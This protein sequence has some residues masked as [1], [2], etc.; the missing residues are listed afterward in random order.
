MK[1]GLIYALIVFLLDQA[2]KAAVLMHFRDSPAPVEITP[3]FNLVLA[4]NKGVSFSMFHSDHPVMPW[5]LT[6]VALLICAMIVHWMS[7]EKNQN[8]VN[9][10]GLILG[11]ALGN[12]FDR[13]HYGAV[14]DFLDFHIGV[15]HW[16]AFNIGDSAICIGAGIILIWNIFLAPAEK[17]S[18]HEEEANNDSNA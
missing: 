16:P 1:K 3:F 12:I 17:L 15:H 11:G 2:S 8:T 13:V 7:M 9:C 18:E 5:V 4:W 10:F 14:V 6:G